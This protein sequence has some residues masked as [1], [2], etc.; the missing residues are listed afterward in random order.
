MLY[1]LFG[2][3]IKDELIYFKG[4]VEKKEPID[5]E[6][7]QPKLLPKLPIYNEDVSWQYRV[8]SYLSAQAAIFYD[9][10]KTP[11]GYGLFK[12]PGDDT[13]PTLLIQMELTRCF[14]MGLNILIP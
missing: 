10:F 11:I 7:I 6:F 2:Y 9:R 1:E 14:S 12:Q 3:K 5:V 8:Q 13:K 4:H